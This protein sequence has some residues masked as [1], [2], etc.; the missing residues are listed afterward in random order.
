MLAREILFML[1]AKQ[2]YACAMVAQWLISLP[3]M[4]YCCPC[5]RQLAPV[6]VVFSAELDVTATAKDPRNS[7]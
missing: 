4:R 7:N 2:S 5:L 3:E 6:P 1:A